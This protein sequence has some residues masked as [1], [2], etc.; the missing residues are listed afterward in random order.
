MLAK[1]SS[2]RWNIVAG[3]VMS[4]QIAGLVNKEQ[5]AKEMIVEMFEEA[6]AVYENKEYYLQG[7]GHNTQEWVKTFT[8]TM[9]KQKRY[10]KKQVKR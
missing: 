8:I 6:E 7:K 2:K 1:S 10:L 4:G 9:K 5:T 3:S